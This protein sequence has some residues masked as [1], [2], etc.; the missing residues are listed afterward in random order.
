[1]SATDSSRY[2]WV[3]MK[4]KLTSKANWRFTFNVTI[5]LVCFCSNIEFL[6]TISR[7]TTKW[8]SESTLSGNVVLDMLMVRR[9]TAGEN[10]IRL[11][12]QQ[13]GKVQTASMNHTVMNLKYIHEGIKSR[14]NYGNTPYIL[15]RESFV[16]QSAV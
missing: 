10:H 13:Y 15:T 3:N 9:R 8:C 4:M 1:M 6:A 14:L 16:F 5:G 11:Y 12:R 2:Q 7:G